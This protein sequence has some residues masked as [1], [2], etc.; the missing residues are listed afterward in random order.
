MR[1]RCNNCFVAARPSLAERLACIFEADLPV[2]PRCQAANCV[3]L[4]LVH[5][6]VPDQKGPIYDPSGRLHVA[7]EPKRDALA[8]HRFDDYAATQDPR[9]VTCPSCMGTPAYE[10]LLTLIA[11]KVALERRIA[12]EGGCCG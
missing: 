10:Q 7:C 12:R 2:C 4:A 11:P 9:A 5:L 8:R 3:E 1:F 6:L